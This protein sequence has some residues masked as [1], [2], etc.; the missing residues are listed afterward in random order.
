MQSF[1]SD[2]RTWLH[3]LP[4]GMKMLL[5]L[6]LGIGMYA[7]Q[8]WQ[9]LLLPTMVCVLIYASLGHVGWRARRL[10][11]PLMW[12]CVLVLGF[13][14]YSQQAALGLVSALRMLSI[15]LMGVA[16]TLTTHPSQLLH[17][18]EWALQPLEKL[19][20]Q[21]QRIALQF[22]LMLR[23][24]EHFFMVWQQ[25]DDAH[26][27]RTGKSAGL[28]LLAPLSLHMLQAAQRVADTL[29]LRLPR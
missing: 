22:A 3:H 11:W 13:H 23:F 18:L 6:C 4:A 14:A 19:G 17:T 9:V 24:I 28:R 20:V 5:L 15:T 10:L 2:Q 25:L 26:K 12:A 27:L 7:S 21:P 8:Q 29:T 16:F 1:Y